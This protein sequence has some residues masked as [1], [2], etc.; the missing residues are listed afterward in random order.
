[1]SQNEINFSSAIDQIIRNIQSLNECKLPNEEKEENEVSAQ[2]HINGDIVL[3][4][5]FIE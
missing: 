3:E 2:T 5:V 4:E 1:L